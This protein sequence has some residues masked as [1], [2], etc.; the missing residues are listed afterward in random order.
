MKKFC[1]VFSLLMS[2]MVFTACGAGIKYSSDSNSSN[3]SGSKQTKNAELVDLGS[4]P[5]AYMLYGTYRN[6]E[7]YKD[8]SDLDDHADDYDYMTLQLEDSEEYEVQV[9]PMELQADTDFLDYRIG[10]K[11]DKELKEEVGLTDQQISVLHEYW[12]YDHIQARYIDR[13]K[14]SEDGEYSYSTN[15]SFQFAYEVVGNKVYMGLEAMITDEADDT[16]PV[17]YYVQDRKDWIEYSYGFDGLDL[18]LSK[19]GKSTRLRAFDILNAEKKNEGLYEW[20]YAKNSTSGY[21]GIIHLIL[22]TEE[23]Y[24][25]SIEW[26][27]GR[28]GENVTTKIDGNRFTLT[29]DSTYRYG[30]DLGESEEGEGGELTGIFLISNRPNG[31]LDGGLSICID[32]KWYPYVYDSTA[33]WDDELSDNLGTDAD[34]SSMSEDELGELKENQTAVSSGLMGAFK[35]QGLDSTKIDESTGTV[36]MDNNVLFAWDKADLS[37]EGKAYLDQFLAAYVPV[38]SS[39]I[40]DGKVSTIVVEGYT[41]SAGDEAYNLKLSEERAKTVADYIK[42]GYPE[43]TNAI[44]VVGNG[45]NNLILDGEGKEDVASIKTCRSQICPEDRVMIKIKHKI[46]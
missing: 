23:G 28:R 27:D 43:L 18:I 14:Y 16:K 13:E 24:D 15:N 32:G 40:E 38:I 1:V 19:D 3:S 45:A 22:S 6:E 46:I 35:E 42:A 4:D 44:E 33:Y 7:M 20:G 37:E 5:Q 17:A 12:Q 21:D 10:G 26:S 11:T 9:F 36:Q 29:W 39:A 2:T 30:Y 31:G 25:S 8:D 41:D 34:V